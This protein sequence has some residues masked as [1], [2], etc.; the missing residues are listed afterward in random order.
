MLQ[1]TGDSCRKNSGS[2][3]L[4]GGL[5]SAVGKSSAADRR[6][7]G[8]YSRKCDRSTHWAYGGKNLIELKPSRRIGGCQSFVEIANH[9]G[10][11]SGFSVIRGDKGGLFFGNKCCQVCHV[12]KYEA[13]AQG[14]FDSSIIGAAQLPGSGDMTPYFEGDMRSKLERSFSFLNT[15]R[16]DGW[17]AIDKCD[18]D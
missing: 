1:C 12:Q 16:T 9:Y 11:G 8:V 5:I 4:V 2:P 14:Y 7:F 15:R 17:K 18:V 6:P 3:T 13:V 10:C